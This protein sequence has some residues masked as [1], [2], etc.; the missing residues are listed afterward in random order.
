MKSYLK[1]DI[2]TLYEAVKKLKF[3]E[4]EPVENKVNLMLG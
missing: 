3:S 1:R 2:G 4:C